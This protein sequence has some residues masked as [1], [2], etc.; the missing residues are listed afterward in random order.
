MILTAACLILAPQKSTG[1]P[2]GLL[3]AIGLTRSR[4]VIAE[5]RRVLAWTV[6]AEGQGYYFDQE[7]AIAFV[8]NFKRKALPSSMS[9]AYR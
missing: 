7:D 9:A 1:I 8:Q 5:G 3:K 4:R 2:D 6:T